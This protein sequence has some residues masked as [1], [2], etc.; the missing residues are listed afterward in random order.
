MIDTRILASSTALA[1]LGLM[2]AA[3]G[4][5]EAPDHD[6]G[7]DVGS[8]AASDAHIDSGSGADADLDGADGSG[9]LAP[10]E[11]IDWEGY[12]PVAPTIPLLTADQ[13]QASLRAIFGDDIAIPPITW[14]VTEAGGFVAV[15]AGDATLSPRSVEDLERAARDIASQIF[16][17]DRRAAFLSCT[18]AGPTDD[19]CAAEFIDRFGL[20]LWRRPLTDEERG[21]LVGLASEAGTALGD[22]HAGLSWALVALVQSPNFLFRREVGVENPQT[23]RRVLDDYELASRLAFVLWNTTPDDALLE[24]AGLGEL[25]DD[26][27]LAG[28]VDRML[29]DPRAE[30]GILEFFRQAWGLHAL[31][32]LSKDPLVFPLMASDLGGALLTESELTLRALIFDD[33]ADIREVLLSQRTFVDR[34]LAALYG[35]AAPVREGFGETWLPESGRRRGF[36]GQGA[37][38]ALGAHPTMSSPTVRGVFVRERLL[39]ESIPAPPAGVDT[40]IPEP[41]GD[42]LTLRDRVAEHLEN[43]TCAACHRLTDPIGLGF[44]NFDGIG[45]FRELDNGERIDATGEFD[46]RP[47]NDAWDLAGQIGT[48][49]RFTR[50]LVR[51]LVRFSTGQVEGFEQ[52]RVLTGLEDQFEFDGYRW[53]PL[54][55]ALVL[56]P[57]FRELGPID[58]TTEGSGT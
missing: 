23:G 36:L 47:F 4:A 17:P 42:A 52:R 40:S 7:A 5:D 24:A 45:V 2:L 20:R 8:D 29:S 3:C 51:N 19:A 44:E 25:S 53:L 38:L 9:T 27:T 37:F 32:G 21:R 49:V 16:S 39:C 26:S 54:V 6:V 55:R 1:A 34:R 15:G 22:F 56:S 14:S 12:V 50:C 10:P 43:E 18:P 33:E 41:S 30:D 35:V 31:S 11:S 58:D 48:D 46:G 28:H 57:A 13:L